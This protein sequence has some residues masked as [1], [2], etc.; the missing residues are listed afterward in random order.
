MKVSVAEA[1]ICPFIFNNQNS[2]MGNDGCHILCATKKCMAWVSTKEFSQED[3]ESC[4]VTDTARFKE[5][6][7]REDLVHVTRTN[8]TDFFDKLIPLEDGDKE[9]YCIKLGEINV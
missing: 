6:H 4:S 5:L 9:G 2:D 8:F 7:A 1:K 3:F